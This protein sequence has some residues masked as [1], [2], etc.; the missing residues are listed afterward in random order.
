MLWVYG[1]Y[2]YFYSY[3]AGID[4]SRQYRRQI[5]TTKVYPRAVMNKGL[6]PT[7][8][9]PLSLTKTLNIHPMLCQ[10]WTDT[11]G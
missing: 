9:N 8:L 3:N 11:L 2:N 7:N 5:L 1:H 6:T 10:C 4:F